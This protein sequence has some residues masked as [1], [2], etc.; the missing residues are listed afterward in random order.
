MQLAKRAA[1]ISPSPTLAIDAQ[2][3]KMLKQGIKVIN[4]GAGEP[5][6][7]TPDHIKE[8]AKAALDRGFTRYTAVGGTDELKSAIIAKLK[9][10]N[11]L[12][13]EPNQIVVSVGAKHSLYNLFQ[14]VCEQ[15]DEVILP[16][17]YW[18]SY[19]EQIK[20]AGG[21]PKVVQTAER[22]GFKL[23]PEALED[24][25]S[26]K[27]RFVLINSP[28]NPTGA[29]Y[30][31]AELLAL[32]EVIVRHNLL[33][34]SDEIYEKLIYEGEGHVS[35]AS[36]SPQL[37]ALTVVI[38]G[39]SKA[40]A[41]TGWRIGYAAGPAEVVKAMTSLQSHA[42][43]NPAS[44]AQA[45]SVAALTGSQEPLE[46]MRKE[47][48]GRRDY[49]WKRLNSLPGVTCTKPVGA[50]YLYP[51]VSG[52]F[53]KIHQGR[54]ITS[55]DDLAELLLASGKVA[56]VPSAAFGTTENIRL[57]YAASMENI[58]EG[59]DRMQAFISSL[60]QRDGSLA[61]F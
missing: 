22:D 49:M 46:I 6:F 51:N 19:F 45:A 5:D 40:Y 1:L 3:K 10:D 48:A 44:V 52:L 33:V 16:A 47:F 55:P 15:G 28:G 14:V 37:K 29:V 18:V 43:S 54:T 61:S 23:T 32:G 38:N 56:V 9:N 35:I 53:G 41:M 17:P 4:F 30:T 60:Q 27:T 20:L 7:D 31:R 58:A 12:E 42:T 2:A 39:V 50:F 13:Y 57:S 34:I 11:D 21:L 26:A 36:L 59:L 24:A 8:A 25:I